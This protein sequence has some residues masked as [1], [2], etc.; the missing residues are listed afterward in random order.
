MKVKKLAKKIE[1][2]AKKI[3]EKNVQSCSD[4]PF[5]NERLDCI[6]D[7]SMCIC[8]GRS[9]AIA[10]DILQLEKFFKESEKCE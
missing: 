7:S 4:C 8:V 10:D 5:S 1:K 3:E 6:L 2:L 9:T